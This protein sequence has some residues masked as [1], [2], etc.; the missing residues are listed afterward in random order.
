M[1]VEAAC[2]RPVFALALA[3]PAAPAVGLPGNSDNSDED[4]EDK[5]KA[6]MGT[7]LGA[8]KSC[9]GWDRSVSGAASALAAPAAA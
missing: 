5:L 2:G 1:S 9:P 4:E 3:A 6:L 8:E 7:S